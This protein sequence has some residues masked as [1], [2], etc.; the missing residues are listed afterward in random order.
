MDQVLSDPPK[1]KADGTVEVAVEPG[2]D[3][4]PL[5][6]DLLPPKCSCLKGLFDLNHQATCP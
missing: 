4:E 1:L 2:N 6:K 3:L 5:S